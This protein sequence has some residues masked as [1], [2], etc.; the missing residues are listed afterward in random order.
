MSSPIMPLGD[1]VVAV[2]EE[3]KTKTASGIFLP[4]NAKEQPIMAEVIAVGDEVKNVKNG[5]KIV[6]SEYRATDLKINNKDYL[7]IKLEDV[8]GIVK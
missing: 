2:K 7:I 8:L 3:A 4:E 5:D 1:R 6:Y